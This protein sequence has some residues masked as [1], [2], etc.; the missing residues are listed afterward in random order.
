[1]EEETLRKLEA[2][3]GQTYTLD[4]KPIGKVLYLGVNDSPD[5]Y[6][7]EDDAAIAAREEA[8][9]AEAEEMNNEQ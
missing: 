5:R 2:P 6:A 9:E 8:E 1:M 4:G 7:L 3:E